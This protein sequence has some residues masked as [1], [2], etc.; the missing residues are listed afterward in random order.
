MSNSRL[1]TVIFIVLFSSSFILQ[2]DLSLSTDDS[3]YDNTTIR[4]YIPK[5]TG[6]GED[7]INRS[8]NIIEDNIIH[9]SSFSEPKLPVILEN[10]FVHKSVSETLVDHDPIS[11][12]GN[13]D[14]INQVTTEGWL[15]NGSS[16]DPYI[17]ENYNFN[18]LTG[19]LV[20]IRNTNLSFK[21]INCYLFNGDFG[22]YLYNV[23]NGNIDNNTL[24]GNRFSIYNYNVSKG[25]IINNKI[26]NSEGDSIRLY[27]SEENFISNN[28]VTN[29]AGFAIRLGSSNKTF[30]LNN[31]IFNNTAGIYLTSSINNS[32]LENEISN[33]SGSGIRL[34]D[35]QYIEIFNN[36]IF[37]NGG[38][39]DSGI[40]IDHSN[41]NFVKNNT[42]FNNGF[43][44]I[45]LDSSNFTTVERN[46]CS[47]NERYGITLGSYSSEYA[48]HNYIS[49]N[50]MQDNG[51]YGIIMHSGINNTIYNNSVS[52]SGYDGIYLYE[53]VN[54]SI[55]EDNT[56]FNNNLRGIRVENADNISIINNYIFNNSNSGIDLSSSFNCNIIDNK[57][58]NNDYY[59]IELHNSDDN[60]IRSNELAK[61]FP[62][63]SSQAVDDGSNNTFNFN[64]WDDWITP[65]VNG[66]HIVDQP[67]LIDGS[68]NNL[69]PYPLVYPFQISM[70]DPI[71]IDGNDAL[72]TF[73][74][75]EGLS[76]EGTYS[77]PY[78]I[79]N[80]FINASTAHGI[81]IRSTD[82][83]LTIR[84]C[85]IEDG[86]STAGISLYYASNVNISN[87]NVNNN[88]YGICLESSS[89]NMLAGNTAS[90][91]DDHGIML[92]VSSNHNTLAGN[93]ASY[94]KQIGIYLESSS[95]NTLSANNASYNNYEGIHL[96]G[97]SNN[98]T[99]A[100]NNASY[101]TQRGIFLWDSST[102]TLVRNTA[103]YNNYTGIWLSSSS[104]NNT[105]A[106]NT[107]SYNEDDGIHLS[108]SSNHNTLAGNTASY[109]NW[110]GIYLQ[111]SSY[112]NTINFNAIYGNTISQAY[113][114][115]QNNT[116][117]FNY[118]DDWTSPDNNNDGVVDSPYQ[119]DGSSNN[120]DPYPLVN[121]IESNTHLLVKPSIIYPN[122]G[123]MVS[124]NT[125]IEW[126]KSVDSLEHNVTYSIYYSSDDGVSWILVA[127]DLVATSLPW[128]TSIV[129]DG[130]NYLIKIIAN[131]SEGLTAETILGNN[132]TIDNNTPDVILTTLQNDTLLNSLDIID[133]SITDHSLEEV[134]Y[135]WDNDT[136]QSLT[137]PFKVA[138]PSD[139]GYHWLTVYANDSVGHLA[140]KKYRWWINQVPNINLV[141]PANNSIQKDGT[142]IIL[143][144][145][146]N[147]LDNVWYNWDNGA[148]Q[149]FIT[150]WNVSFSL[151]DG[152]HWMDVYANDKDGFLSSTQFYF[153]SDLVSPVI[154]LINPVNDTSIENSLVIELAVTDYSLDSVWYNWDDGMNQS[155]ASPYQIG[156]PIEEG[157]HWLTV[158]ATDSV[159]HFT[160]QKY[161]WSI[162]IPTTTTTT[163]TSTTS[164][165]STPSTT[166]RESI[167]V[168]TS[169]FELLPLLMALL[170]IITILRRARRYGMI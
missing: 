147:N 67:Y 138:V 27:F 18:N 29:N 161:R 65:D 148:N 24:I 160:V 19:S 155:L 111:Q 146:D 96:W 30:I 44:G 31:S 61:N 100:E 117:S 136:N 120:Q 143:N 77:S 25:E 8:A 60:I 91:N 103:S 53:W 150:P 98:N 123:E 165:I 72:A 41:N 14:F 114:D 152:W 58:T 115:G 37:N 141:S 128:E 62:I 124:G 107:A 20:E 6:N 73:I 126:M 135:N 144:I 164:S 170:S 15:G 106:G 157:Y 129:D 68:S 51:N 87:N 56:L 64:Y 28:S 2:M 85:T 75:D 70:H 84:D 78:I 74:S 90:Y 4:N 43:Y 40:H 162:L 94:N 108:S 110:D 10:D 89:H 130:S 7:I 45:Y 16:L 132:F 63:G 47:L 38:W 102:N 1:Y 55:I 5:L 101:N 105:L 49:N 109:N 71:F 159:G 9:S 125:T 66:D 151:S 142:V 3:Y 86:R 82:A 169:G 116:F 48:S 22:I 17:I 34:L 163:T 95:H 156:V 80:F 57:I 69:D 35:S 50:L 104:N 99:L 52:E 46:N 133:L 139:D 137:S 21:I 154:L 112:N 83:Y 33:N 32:I 13:P 93:T 81:E 54:N 11:I 131:C 121:P 12:D 36:D 119:I 168:L 140:V 158:Y 92:R 59:G 76:G 113:D 166:K 23:K 153:Y 118:W 122:G 39:E 97:S 134:W 149:S 145:V 127:G 26:I 79:E 167:P 42:I 88:S